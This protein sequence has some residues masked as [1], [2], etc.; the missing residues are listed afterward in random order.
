M[1]VENN[2]EVGDIFQENSIRDCVL[3]MNR[4]SWRPSGV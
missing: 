4:M 1:K 2:A 3:K